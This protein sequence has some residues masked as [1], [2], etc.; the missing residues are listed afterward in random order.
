MVSR[1]VKELKDD[2]IEG[3]DGPGK[4][5]LPME[6]CDRACPEKIP[7]SD[8]M[9]APS[10]GKERRTG[11][12]FVAA[13]VVA[14]AAKWRRMTLPPAP[15]IAR[16]GSALSAVAGLTRMTFSGWRMNWHLETG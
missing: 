14:S 10:P 4:E 15:A 5:M 1:G 2:R 13:G 3:V 8:M 7:I 12:F 11:F 6:E 9:V 16:D